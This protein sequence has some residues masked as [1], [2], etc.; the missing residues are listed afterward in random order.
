MFLLL[1]IL[2]NVLT[3]GAIGDNK[4]DNTLLIDQAIATCAQ[5]GGGT[6]VIPQGIF[7]TGTL[8]MRS[9]V[10]LRLEKGA[11]LRGINDLKAY[12]KLTTT[13]DRKSTRLNSSHANISYAVFCLKKKTKTQ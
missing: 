1:S 7:L 5:R 2:I 4:T 9:N 13:Q 11:V 6:V 10:T 8:H 3:L 12:E